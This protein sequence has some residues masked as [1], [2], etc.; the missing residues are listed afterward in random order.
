MKLI[1]PSN[2]VNAKALSKYGKRLRARDYETMIK[3]KH[4]GDIVV[5]LRNNTHY[6][7]YLDRVNETAIHRGEL[8]N[9]LRKNLFLDMLELCKYDLMSDDAI[10]HFVIR[11]N[12]IHEIVSFLSLLALGHEEDYF[13]IMPNYLQNY[14]PLNLKKM[15][16]AKSYNEF[17]EAISNTVYYKPLSKFAIN[18]GEKLNISK[19]EDE[20][21][22]FNIDRLFNKLVNYTS[23]QD[24]KDFFDIIN[25]CTN[26]H[27]IV[28]LKTYYKL[29]PE[30]IFPHLRHS[31]NL[32]DAMLQ[33]MCE[34]N[35]L[36]EIQKIFRKTK[37]GKKLKGYDFD[38]YD[39]FV[40]QS[41][42]NLTEHNLH[43]SQ[44]TLIILMSYLFI[45]EIELQNVIHCIEGVRYALPP[46]EIKP[47]LVYKEM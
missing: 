35:S 20:L 8:E 3:F 5:Y 13:Y 11:R 18:E 9:I 4:V 41:T 30:E 28:R 6:V 39:V 43:F 21:D 26:F 38:T 24:V 31:G 10:R 36:E 32:S 17:L 27:R 29:P 25:D 22:R 47:L 40:Q 12:E 2:A 19:I 34:T 45:S 37:A 16:L 7:N 44:N 1:N 15:A 33:S 46:E 14:T 23:Y 42:F